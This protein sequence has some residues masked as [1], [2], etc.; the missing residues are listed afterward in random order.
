M[1]SAIF[2]A[3][4]IVLAFASQVGAQP[5]IVH[6]IGLLPGDSGVAAATNSQ[7]DLSIAAGGNQYLAAWSDYRG[8][9]AG[10]QTVQSDCDIF[11]IRLDAN[12]DP[13]DVVPFLIA[14]GMGFQQRPTVAWNGVNWLVLFQSQDPT[15]GYFDT[16]I[17]AVRVS[18]QGQ[19]LDETPTSFPLDS[20]SPNTIGLTLSGLNGQWLV[21]RCVYHGDGYGTYL[22]GQRISADGQL[23]D[24]APLMLNDWVY[25]QLR[26]IA[27][28]GE[29]LVVGPDWNDSATLKARRINANLQ[30]VAPS[31]NLPQNTRSIAGNGAGEFYVTWVPDFVNLVGSR[32]TGT[33]SLL[34]PGGVLLIANPFWNASMTH[35]GTNWW[36][37]RT[38]GNE[39]WTTRISAAGTVLDP[40]GIQLPID[41]QGSVNNLYDPQ[42]APRS[43]GGVM[44]A[45]TD[46]R[47]A[48]GN[49]SNG[50]VMPVS[51]E[52]VAST[53][54]C[55]TS[56]S[57][58]QR[59]SGIAIGP[60]GTMAVAFVSEVA[61]DD[62]VLVQFLDA[63]GNPM[64]SG[65]IEVAQAP[66]IG[67][68]GIAWNGST[69]MITWDQGA[70]GL[71][72]TSIR[73]RRMDAAG[74]PIGE[75]FAVMPG[76]SP[77]IDAL[78]EDFCIA[79]TRYATNPQFIDLWVNRINGPTAAPMDG[80][81]GIRVASGYYNGLTRTRAD[82]SQWLVCAHSMWSHDASQGDAVL[83]RIPPTGTPAPAFNPTPV[84]GGSGDPDIAFSGAN[85]LIV[86]R[87]NSLANA[88][89]YVS[90][91]IMNLNGTYGPAF[92]IAEAPGRQL[93]PTVSWNGTMFV[94]AWDDQRNQRSFYDAR[95]DVFGT[96]VSET[97]VVLD[98]TSFPIFVGPQG[99]AAS[100]V[101]KPFGTSFLAL[102]RFVT[103]PPFDSFRI[104]LLRLGALPLTGDLNGD[105]VVDADD[106]AILIAVMTGV[107][108]DPIHVSGCDFNGDGSTNG[109]DLMAFVHAMTP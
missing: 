103:D 92:T 56:S 12:G 48:L 2:L 68:C 42:V 99:C 30:P 94:V 16:F 25:G 73:A 91:R 57:R 66:T 97:G 76:Q 1:K 90:G 31:F 51:S 86:W 98:S 44:F 70:A 50:F 69:F 67:V 106:V 32:M 20:F 17:R 34:N 37:V 38:A 33:G 59:S 107:D 15:P 108:T 3:V 22:A 104:S 47:A 55:L 105:G 88:N 83:V 78:G 101:S 52:N 6:E 77:S 27:S 95:T 41:V 71:T 23:I 53:E 10:N 49:D 5:A 96:R 36:L 29:Y 75:S 8:R 93:R 46:S 65:P 74:A 64:P 100:M 79:A 109:L 80:V 13:I 9:S 35:D 60:G 19:V 58:N 18:P 11:G 85:Y 40:N 102:T 14:G 28:N 72:T 45:W 26:V 7:V 87:S 89:N 61:N 24:N 54:R 21:A 39:A 81:N 84:S 4:S 62:R 43:G 63:T 82:G